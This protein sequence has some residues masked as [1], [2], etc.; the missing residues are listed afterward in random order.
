MA[1]RNPQLCRLKVASLIE[2]LTG[3]TQFFYLELVF[4]L[5]WAVEQPATWRGDPGNERITEK[6][7][8]YAL[9][10]LVASGETTTTRRGHMREP[11]REKR[12]SRPEKWLDSELFPTLP[13]PQ[14]DE[15]TEGGRF[16]SSRCLNTTSAQ[17]PG[18]P[19]SYGD[20]GLTP[21]QARK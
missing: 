10:T 21:G 2:A 17:I 8:R 4:W 6:L 1:R 13:N 19:L 12:S 3:E 9:L 5:K 7:D 11:N 18:W 14:T 15:L 16:T 20:T